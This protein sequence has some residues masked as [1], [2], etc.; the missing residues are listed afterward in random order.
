MKLA[1]FVLK[2]DKWRE[3]RN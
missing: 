3:M 2:T 1:E